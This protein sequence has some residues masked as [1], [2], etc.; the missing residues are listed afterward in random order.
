MVRMDDEDG[1]QIIPYGQQFTTT[2]QVV[3]FLISYGSYLKSTGFLFGD[4]ASGES[5]L[6]FH[7]STIDWA[8]SAKEFL[9]WLEQGW[10]TSIVLSLT[11]AGTQ[12]SFD[13]GFGVVDDLT[14][15]Y[16]GTRLTNSDDTV[17]QTKE[18]TTF[19][20]GT[21]FN[22]ILKDSTK[23]IH[24]LDIVVVAY[25]H[26]LVFDNT[27]VFNDIIYSPSLGNRQYRMKINGFKTRDWDGSLY[28]PGFLVNFRDVELWQPVT[29]Y[30]KGDI[31]EYKNKYYT[32][33]V[34][35]PGQNKFSENNWMPVNS[36]LLNK[37]L[38]PNMAFNAQQFE[39][40]Y[41]VDKFDVNSNADTLA[42]NATGFVPRNYLDDIGLNNISQHKFYLGMIREKGTKAAINAF[43]RAKLPYIDNDVTIDEQFAIRLGSYG[44]SNNV[45]DI[46]LSLENA[47]PL[48]GAYVVELINQNDTKSNMWNSYRPKDLLIKPAAY[49][50]NIFSS[51]ESYPMQVGTGG[52]VYPSDVTASIYDIQKI[53]NLSGP[54]T[55][56]STAGYG[57]GSR[58]W[59]AS[60]TEGS[61]NVYRLSGFENIKIIVAVSINTT[62]ELE[63]TTNIPHGLNFNDNILIKN[64]TTNDKNPTNLSGFYRVNKVIN[65]TTFRTPIYDGVKIS[66]SPPKLTNISASLLKIKSVKYNDRSSF[67]I[68]TPPGGWRTSDKVWING[69]NGNWEVLNRYD[70][71]IISQSLTPVFSG[72][73]DNFGNQMDIKSTED[74]MVVGAPGKD[75]GYVYVYN[76]D[77]NASWAV[78]KGI[79]PANS[80]TSQFGYSV[81]YNDLDFAIVGAPGS[82]SGAGLAYIINASNYKIGVNQILNPPGMSAG[83]QFG[84]AVTSSVD[85]K[86]IAIGAPNDNTVFIYRY[87]EVSDP[88]TYSYQAESATEFE[89]PQGILG[90][91][92]TVNDIKVY[93]NDDMKIPTTDYYI[94]GNNVELNFTPN[95]SDILTITYESYYQYVTE[96]SNIENSGN[97]GSSIS[98]SKDGSQLAIGAP[99][100]T[101]VDSSGNSYSNMGQVY[102]YERTIETFIIP[103]YTEMFLTADQSATLYSVT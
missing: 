37:K 23:G 8:N 15:G 31:V 55:T 65:A 34:F 40:F 5:E 92:L 38:I 54:S 84:Y 102:I 97:F 45:S 73:S 16:S 80:N 101:V 68:D 51:T 2:Q 42:R 60:D 63:F 52:P 85:G 14:N 70:N 61:W 36:N 74:I 22:L 91:G 46:E 49:D 64:G 98:F 76:K 12:I 43:L 50:N 82:N 19:R 90:R 7:N 13:A 69:L 1:I 57:E 26:T 24:L 4:V 75:S 20:N 9:Y 103:T 94:S 66:I 44:G 88:V 6:E 30:Y 81:K 33:K 95:Y 77:L 53:Y 62:S 18:F 25:E 21:N 89:L 86:W 99:N 58:I 78:A 79:S 72:D 32:A 10:D 56:D 11:P 17:L 87:T 41:D 39:N 47:N 93:I 96:F 83:D 35:I 59:V 29:D 3:D 100:L 71:Y 28:A 48:N 67:A 27:T